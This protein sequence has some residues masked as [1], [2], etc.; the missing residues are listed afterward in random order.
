MNSQQVEAIMQTLKARARGD[1]DRTFLT[2][3][4]DLDAANRTLLERLDPEKMNTLTIYMVHLAEQGHPPLTA[5]GLVV[6]GVAFMYGFQLGHDYAV[7][8]GP[9]KAESNP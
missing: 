9:L 1:V 8:Y 2:Q 3:L 7:K 4:M 5:E 6:Y